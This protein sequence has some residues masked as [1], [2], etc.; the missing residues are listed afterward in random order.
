MSAL[1]P[2]ADI[3]Q[4]GRQVALGQNR[5]R[6]PQDAPVL[7]VAKG[8]RWSFGQPSS[9]QSDWDRQTSKA[10]RSSGKRGMW[11]IAFIGNELLTI[12]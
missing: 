3:S 5:T 1:S 9:R 12:L 10:N 11:L 8:E 6:A 2:E 4:A 7:D